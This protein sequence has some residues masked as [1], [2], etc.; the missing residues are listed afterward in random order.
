MQI[1][2]QSIHFKADASLV[3]F[4]EEKLSKLKLFHPG[5]IS[6]DVHFRIDKDQDRENKL[7]EVKLNVPGADLYSSRRATS[8]EEA[9]VE[10]VEALRRQLEKAR[11]KAA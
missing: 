6:A 5:I 9:S 10:V 2:V 3:R 11:S 1:Q 8:F 7:V 4:I